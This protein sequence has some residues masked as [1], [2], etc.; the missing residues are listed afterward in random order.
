MI[1]RGLSSTARRVATG[2][3]EK[4]WRSMYVLAWALSERDLSAL[5]TACDANGLPLECHPVDD[6]PEAPAPPR[7]DLLAAFVS[8]TTPLPAALSPADLGRNGAYVVT[9]HAAV[10]AG[11]TLAALRSGTSFVMAEPLAAPRLTSFLTYLRDVAA[12]AA[13]QVVELDEADVLTTPSASTQLSPAE[14]KALRALGAVR[15]T[16]VPRPELARLT[17][18]DPRDLVRSLQERFREVG[19]ASQILKVPHM[20]FRLVGEVRMKAAP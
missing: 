3:Y 1:A 6:T 7:N 8:A 10:T 16:I 12:P 4:G 17:G 15:A 11:N 18:E 5:R 2:T 19:A 9:V 20:G 13:T 14:G